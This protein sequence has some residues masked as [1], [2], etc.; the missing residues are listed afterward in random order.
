MQ[1]R[2]ITL[3]TLFTSVLLLSACNDDSSD[4]KSTGNKKADSKQV[5]NKERAKNMSEDDKVSYTLGINLGLRIK[6]SRQQN[7][8][9]DKLIANQFAAGIRDAIEKEPSSFALTGKEMKRVTAIYRNKII[10]K[11][12]K[13]TQKAQQESKDFLEKKKKEDGILVDKSGILYKIIKAGT[14]KK[15]TPTDKIKVHYRGSLINGKE[16]DSSYRTGKPIV[17]SLSGRLI[18]AWKT[19][20]PKMKEGAKWTLYVPSEQA[21]GSRG[22]PPAIRPYS[23]LIFNIELI[24]INPKPPVMEKAEKEKEKEKK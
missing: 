3:A 16:F 15:P 23:T 7:N 18:P 14:G 9:T 4:K 21:Y 5:D 2:K 10:E 12:K 6:F 13:A 1:I 24:K 22:V 8:E 19:M 17:F 20:L 11:R